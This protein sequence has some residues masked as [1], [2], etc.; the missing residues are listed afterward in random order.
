MA[1]IAVGDAERGGEESGGIS[2]PSWAALT[3]NWDK[4]LAL[5]WES[6]RTGGADV[7]G[8]RNFATELVVLSGLWSQFGKRT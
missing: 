7:L 4:F 5:F 6:A 3:L 1:G 8:V 2:W